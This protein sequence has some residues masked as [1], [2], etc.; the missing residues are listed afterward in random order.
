MIT[1]GNCK[2]CKN[3]TRAYEAEGLLLHSRK[4]GCVGKIIINIPNDYDESKFTKIENSEKEYG[5]CYFLTKEDA[6]EKGLLWSYSRE[7]EAI[8][9]NENFGCIKFD[10]K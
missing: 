8:I 4:Q 2:D 5:T 3:W 10:A 1:I 7:C 9:T 6:S